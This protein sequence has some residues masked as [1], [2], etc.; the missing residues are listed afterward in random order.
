MNRRDWHGVFPAI[1]TPFRSDL[2]VDHDALARHVSWLVDAGCK[3]VVPLGS[4]GEAATLSFNEKIEILRTCRVAVGRRVPVVAGVAGLATADCVAL[5]REA[6]RVG[7]DG[8]MAL[9]AYVYYS[10]WRETRAHYSAIIGATSLSCMLYNNPLAYRTDVTAQQLAELAGRHENLHAMKESSGDVRRITAV[11]EQL[12]D[13][14]AVFAG[15]DDMILEAVPAGASGWIAGLVNALPVES[16]QLFDLAAA[17][18][19]EQA[20]ELYQWF[21]PL[22]RMDTVPKF[23]QLIKLVQAEVGRGSPAVRPPRLALEGD[24]LRDALGVIR[25]QLASRPVS[26]GSDG[27]PSRFAARVRLVAIVA[28]LA[29]ASRTS[30]AQVAQSGSA[31]PRE[32]PAMVACPWST[33]NDTSGVDR[34]APPAPVGVVDPPRARIPD[35]APPGWKPPAKLKEFAA[36]ALSADRPKPIVDDYLKYVV[37]APPPDI[38][39][40]FKL[41]TSFYKK[42]ADASGYPIL[43]SA[44]VPDAAVAIVRDQVNYMLGN[45][46]DVR[47]TMIAHG[48]RVV[49]MAETEYTMS[50]PEQRRWVVPKYLDPRLTPQERASYYEPGGLGSMTA[51]GYWNPRARGMGGT[52]TTCAEENVLGYYRTRYWGTNICVHEFSHAIMEAGIGNADPKWFQAIVDSYK[53]AKAGC[54]RTANGYSGNTFN[55]YWAGGVE[56]YVGNGGRDRAGLKAADSTLYQL[57]SRLIPESKR[58]P[59]TANVANRTRDQMEAYA[60]DHNPEWWSRE[61]QRQS[62]SARGDSARRAGGAAPPTAGQQQPCVPTTSTENR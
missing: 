31:A 32:R 5:A 49:V 59:V 11:R 6:E 37:T 61:Q 18:D 35:C 39:D 9:P 15:L 40:R 55:E 33:P 60:R 13:H 54:L 14:L 10:D 53:H 19:W 62:A 23:V 36:P 22:L 21:L 3:A 57:V 46:P 42:Y 20:M 51:E 2:S 30:S 4:L 41:D 16:V 45:R 44:K 27:K 43:A 24:E 7:C 28:A 56:W 12:G 26:N 58:V 34:N 8:L 50:I 47:D 38:V 25:R 1:T 17:G 29:G 52:L 48:G